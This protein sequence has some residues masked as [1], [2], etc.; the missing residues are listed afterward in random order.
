MSK[1][2]IIGLLLFGK[3]K[4][5]KKS[6]QPRCDNMAFVK[7]LQLVSDYEFIGLMQVS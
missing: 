7:V 1:S 2:T 3:K 5:K 4:K 6:D